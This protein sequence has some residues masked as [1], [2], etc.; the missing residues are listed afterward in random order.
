[1]KHIFF[2]IDGTLVGESRKLTDNNKKALQQLKEKGHKIYLC[3]G[4]APISV[5]SEVK[6]LGFDGSITS[7]GGFVCIEDELIYE[8]FINQYLL[9]EVLLMF[10]NKKILFSLESKDALYQTPG[11]A[12]FFK[13]KLDAMIPEG[14]L[15]LARFIEERRNEEIRLPIREF[16]ILTTPI[17]KLC[18]LSDD[19]FAFYDCVKY[20]SEFF[21]IVLFSKPEDAYINGEIILKDCTKG[22]GIVRI[23]DFIGGSMKDTIAFGDSMNDYQMIDLVEHGVV[24]KAGPDKLLNVA[25]DYFD[26]PDEDGIYHYLIKA[27]LIDG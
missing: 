6:G 2:D 10:T 22:D 26:D 15:E 21:H 18:F 20:L 8:N 9:S 1:M 14:N 13:Q 11:I 16:D 5:N 7:A 27:G 24:S 12:D 3:T 23:M 25:S 17:T 19:K 4:R